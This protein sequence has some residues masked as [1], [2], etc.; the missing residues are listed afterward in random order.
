MNEYNDF[1]K[2]G[3]YILL[4]SGYDFNF[5][6]PEK[7]I[8]PIEDIAHALSNICRFNGHTKVFYSVAEHSV[9]CSYLVERGFEYD[10]LFH[11]GGEALLG[12][13]ST[14]LKKLLPDFKVIEDK[15]ESSLFEALGV[16]YPLP[17]QIKKA[18][19]Q[20]LALEKKHL[21]PD[22]DSVWGILQGVEVPDI[23]W[24]FGLTPP[25]AK[26]LFLDRYEELMLEKRKKYL[27]KC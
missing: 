6:Y 14:P 20:A 3:S 1:S 25:A 16:T 7:T 21:M 4:H 5:E 18:D 26:K 10:A 2:V 27:K 13:I 17:P 22:T 11:D 24:P 9:L 8:V 12:D 23:I 19:L 15:V